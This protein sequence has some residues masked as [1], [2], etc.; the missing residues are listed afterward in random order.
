[1][2]IYS[3][4]NGWLKAVDRLVIPWIGLGIDDLP[5][6]PYRDWYDDGIDPGR[7]LLRVIKAARAEGFPIRAKAR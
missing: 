5:D 1:M 2:P 3:T 4:F 6:L 7:V